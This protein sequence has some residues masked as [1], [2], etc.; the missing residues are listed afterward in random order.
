MYDLGTEKYGRT[1]V[2]IDN[3]DGVNVGAELLR[4]GHAVP[5]EGGTR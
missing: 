3:T 1:L 5:Y 2:Q 4:G